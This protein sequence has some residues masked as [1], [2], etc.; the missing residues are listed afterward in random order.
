MTTA[1]RTP[2]PGLTM[3]APDIGEREIT[4]VN[5]VLRSGQ[6]SMGP[7][8]IAFE[9]AVAAYSGVR[10]AVAVNSGTAG[11]HMGVVAAGIREGDE[12]ITSPY[13]FV[14]SMSCIVY[15]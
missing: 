2:P 7:E 1:H 3:S 6:L 9:R 8:V 10:Y 4:A 11:L 13:S 12:V 14:A 15:E 5:Q